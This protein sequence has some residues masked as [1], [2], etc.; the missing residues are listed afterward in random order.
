MIHVESE[1]TQDQVRE[2]RTHDDLNSGRPQA[3]GFV[4]SALSGPRGAIHWC[5]SRCSE[6]RLRYTQ[7]CIGGDGG[8]EVKLAQ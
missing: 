4:L 8:E 3:I 1:E 6:K 5:D 7:D 2:R